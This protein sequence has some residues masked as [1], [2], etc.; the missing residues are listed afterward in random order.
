MAVQKKLTIAELKGIDTEYKQ[1][2]EAKVRGLYGAG[3][4]FLLCWNFH[5]DAV[6]AYKRAKEH[7]VRYITDAVR[8]IYIKEEFGK[9]VILVA[10]KPGT[11]SAKGVSHEAR[12]ALQELGIIP[13][14]T[15]IAGNLQ[16][17]SY[18]HFRLAEPAEVVA[19][20]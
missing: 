17:P 7:D 4:S 3:F 15:K 5:K 10:M 8:G 6:A 14:K 1:K 18:N 13:V 9:E 19:F 2:M 16:N 20:L 12:V 11:T